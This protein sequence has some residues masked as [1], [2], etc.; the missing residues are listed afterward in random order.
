MEEEKKE[1]EAV[2]HVE[3][4]GSG[5]L[6]LALIG[7]LVIIIIVQMVTIS[8]LK[9]AISEKRSAAEEAAKPAVISLMSIKDAKCRD[10]FDLTS[11]I[12]SIKGGNV[13]IEAENEAD[14][15]SDGAK[16]LVSKYSIQKV[17]TVIVTG[18]ID[19]ISL[20]GFEKREDALVF[21]KQMPPFTD[22]VSG[23]VEGMVSVIQ[24]VDSTCKNCTD[25]SST[26]ASMKQ[27][28]VG[29]LDDSVI[30]Y[31]SSQGKMLVDKYG[32]KLVP[33]MILSSSIKEYPEIVKNWAEI[34]TVEKDGNYVMRAVN[35]P[36]INLSTGKLTGV[37]S[38]IYLKDS[39]CTTCYDVM[40]HKQI[41]EG[42]YR[43]FIGGEKTYDIGSKEGSA[44]VA[45]YKIKSAPTMIISSDVSAYPN[46]A[47][48]WAQVGTVEAD[49]SYLFRDVSVMGGDYRNIETNE[50]V[51]APVQA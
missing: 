41:L 35:P 2:H 36:F 13:K 49:G 31:A 23:K 38:V 1:P 33:T 39:K 20:Q 42:R 48:I 50:I 14:L 44:L 5:T 30:D 18:E 24:L 8:G 6:K 21:T 26:V 10:C 45:K 22:A 51:K 43:V 27:V 11:A 40:A 32:I 3:S 34:G 9:G 47:G 46:L 16:A 12:S 29:I 15:S 17:P 28:G 37:V 7:V 25:F 19:K 4:K